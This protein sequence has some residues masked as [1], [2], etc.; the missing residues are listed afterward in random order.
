MWELVKWV[1]YI[2]GTAC[3]LSFVL[4]L[5]FV[6]SYITGCGWELGK[7]MGIQMHFYSGNPKKPEGEEK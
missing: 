7:L 2:G 1:L 4:A 3:V 6:L 5:L